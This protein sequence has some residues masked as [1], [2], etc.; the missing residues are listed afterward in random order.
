[1]RLS[2]TLLAAAL[3]VG[4]LADAAH[5]QNTAA[6]GADDLAIVK[7]AVASPARVASASPAPPA[8]R[9]ASPAPRPS[10]AAEA[11]AADARAAASTGREP[12]WFKVRVVDRASGRRK[13]TVNLP[14]GIVRALGDQTIEFG[15]R[16]AD[17]GRHCH[18]IHVSEILRS[19]EAGQDLVEIED[20][21]AS[22]KVWVE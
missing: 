16:E 4:A 12:K 15:C 1:M 2:I 7:R 22:V 8:A 11:R 14:I 13:V 21:D 3:A 18:G 17:L 10:P 9:A 6:T 20:E 19:L 5:A